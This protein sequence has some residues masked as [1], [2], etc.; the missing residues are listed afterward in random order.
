[1]F[2]SNKY[3][4]W[5]HALVD[6]RR[7][8]MFSGYGEWHHVIPKSLGGPNTKA[9]LVRLTARE[10]FVAHMLLTRMTEGANRRKM[11]YALKRT[12]SSKTHVPNSRVFKRVREA[13]AVAVSATLTGRTLTD[14]HRANIS[15]AQEGVPKTE[16]FKQQMSDRLNDAERD[17]PRRAKIKAA[18]TGGKRSEETKRKIAETRRRKFAEGTLVTR[19]SAGRPCW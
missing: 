10:H 13:Y 7:S 1:M 4:R 5:Y 17:A 6:K 8:E 12:V 15:R 2:L 18:L 16:A 11:L 9:N 19:W 14:E 3:A